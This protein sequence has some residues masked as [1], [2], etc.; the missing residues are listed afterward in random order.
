MMLVTFI[1]RIKMRQSYRK[2][3]LLYTSL[4]LLLLVT[5]STVERCIT[6]IWYANLCQYNYLYS[7]TRV[8][9]WRYI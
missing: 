2:T 3:T 4:L 1:T 8:M 5:G 7:R 6:C 9:V